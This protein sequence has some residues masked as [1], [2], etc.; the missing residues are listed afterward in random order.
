MTLR[1]PDLD[2]RTFTQLVDEARRRI[3]A[4]C[5]TWTDLSPHD[6]GMTLVEV[7]AHLTEVMLYRLN[8][9]PD[10]AYVAFLNLLGVQRLAPVAASAVLEF[11]RS[12]RATTPS[13]SPPG[14][15]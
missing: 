13:P 8:R 14:R 12:A 15:G 3:E 4:T 9:L 10:K 7:F 2:D 11:R 5:P 6:P 1:L